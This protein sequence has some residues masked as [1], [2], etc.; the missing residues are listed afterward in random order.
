V[1][2]DP[3]KHHR[4]SIR[5]KGYDYTRRGAYFV[6]VC[7]Q[8]RECLFGSAA[9]AAIC[10]SD[11]GRMIQ[12][13]WDQLPQRFARLELDASVVMPNHFHA[14]IVLVG[15]PLV[16]ALPDDVPPLVDASDPAQPDRAPTRGAPTRTTLGEVVGAFKSLTTNQYG[17]GVR[18]LGWPPFQGRFWQRNYYEHIIHSEESL[19]Q[20]RDYIF[21][22][23]QRW[24]W[25]SENPDRRQ[26]DDFDPWLA[27][28]T[29]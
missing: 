18:D 12:P 9:D 8:H 10:L 17:R 23:P 19:V 5:L 25:D 7:V 4:R 14:S 29:P 11:A 24:Q 13:A 6:T 22:N 28:F 20:I 21:M 26:E 1:L 15:A 16:G 3:D 27:Q 2:Y